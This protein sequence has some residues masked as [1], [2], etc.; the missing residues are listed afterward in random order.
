[1][2]VQLPTSDWLMH[3]NY[4]WTNLQG[5]MAAAELSRL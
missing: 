3:E 4:I 1:M 5:V 2:E